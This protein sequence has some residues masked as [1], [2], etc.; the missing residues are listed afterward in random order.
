MPN[1][2]TPFGFT[3][4]R[5]VDGAAWT[6][7]QSVR[8][9]AAANTKYF[10]TGDP[11]VSLNTGY[12]DLMPAG[13]AANF[14]GI[15]VGCEYLSVAK[16]YVS[17]SPIFPGGDTTKDVVAYVIDDPNVLFAVQTNNSAGGAVASGL[18]TLGNTAQIG[19]SLLSATTGLWSTGGTAGASTAGNTLNGRSGVYL[20]INSYSNSAGSTS[21]FKIYDI[22]NVQTSVNGFPSSST[23]FSSPGNGYD[24]TTPFNIVY[25]TVNASDYRAGVA[26]I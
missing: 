26:G 19:Y 21:P 23:V 9:I 15:F 25:V 4:V 16:G 7:N 2:Y 17:W 6:G 12:I 8:K 13:S 24:A 11:V 20:D 14:A 5:R 3:P 22:P 18:S 10:Y 1:A